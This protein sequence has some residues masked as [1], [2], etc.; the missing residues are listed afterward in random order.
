MLR[1]IQKRV[2]KYKIRLQMLQNWIYQDSILYSKIKQGLFDLE[3]KYIEQK[4]KHDYPEY[5]INE[6]NQNVSKRRKNS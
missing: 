1:K 3:S 5:L 2:N 6:V 4:T